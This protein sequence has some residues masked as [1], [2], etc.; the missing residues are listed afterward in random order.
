M[1]T[2]TIREAEDQ[3]EDLIARAEAGVDVLILREGQP[4]AKLTPL[5][6]ADRSVANRRVFGSLKGKFPMPPDAFFFDPLPEDELRA[7]EGM[8]DDPPHPT[9]VTPRK[10]NISKDKS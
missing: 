2:V 6:R 4:V 9:D 8:N 10:K 7:W 1:T 5:A 3:L